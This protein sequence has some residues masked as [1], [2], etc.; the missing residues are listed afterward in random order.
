MS[1]V[2]ACTASSA[3]R[4][5]FWSLAVVTQR[6]STWPSVSTARWTLLSLRRSEPDQFPQI[7]EDGGE[8][9]RIDPAPGLLGDCRP[10]GQIIGHG[11]PVQTGAGN[12]PEPVDDLAKIMVALGGHPHASGSDTAR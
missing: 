6:A 7:G 2:A 4:A 1:P 10:R 3:T 5:R 12:E 11:S 8:D 9:A